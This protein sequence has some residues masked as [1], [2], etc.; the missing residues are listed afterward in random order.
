MD[1]AK[2]LRSF[3]VGV[4]VLNLAAAAVAIAVNWPS[5]FGQVRT[6]ASENLLAGTAISAPVLPVALLLVTL[7]LASRP[8]AWGWV[9]IGAA[10]LTAVLFFIGA[11]GE[12]VAEGTA[13]TPQSVLVTAG[14]A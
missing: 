10:Y 9:A 1:P 7:L 3:V 5:Q 12:F 11:A 13:D 6:D 4:L 2:R 8:G 14:V